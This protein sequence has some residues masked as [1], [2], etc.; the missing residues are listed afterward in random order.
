[1]LHQLIFAAP[2]PGM[3]EAD[4]QDYW[5]RKHAVHFASKIPGIRAYNVCTRLPLPSDTGT[6]LFSGCA[7][8]WLDD[9]AALM[10]ALQSPEYINGARLDEPNWAAFWQ[11]IALNTETVR[12]VDPEPGAPLPPVKLIV[13]LKRKGGMSLEDY[14][15]H[16]VEV[17]APRFAARVPG[18]RAYHHCH[19]P[20]AFY[21]VGETPLDSAT[22]MWFDDNA[23][24]ETALA[25]LAADAEQSSSL[26]SFTEPRYT[27]IMAVRENW[28]IGNAAP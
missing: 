2:R 25:A 19:T 20:E 5:V 9:V 3:S 4:F 24:L 26:A 8:I 1:M 12:V 28:I 22:M 13:L 18:L 11:T 23:A 17:H 21:A 27:R 10:T 16:C 6:P 7:E 15:R 14:R